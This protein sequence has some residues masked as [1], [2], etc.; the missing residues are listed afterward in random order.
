MET[1]TPPS[2][3]MRQDRKSVKPPM[4]VR[5]DSTLFKLPTGNKTPNQPIR[6]ARVPLAPIRVNTV[7]VPQA[8]VRVLAPVQASTAPVPPSQLLVQVLAP[9]QA[10]TVA[11]PQAQVQAKAVPAP[12]A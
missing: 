12:R 5:R 4:G 6:R 8:L 2:S 9:V 3:P 10:S 11:V 1:I 7:A